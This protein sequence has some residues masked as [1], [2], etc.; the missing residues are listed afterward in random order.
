MTLIRLLALL[1]LIGSGLCFGLFALTSDAKWKR[2]GIWL[3]KGFLAV[4]FV[5]IG[6]LLFTRVL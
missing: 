6:L 4:A 2:W 3:L 5:F 1:L